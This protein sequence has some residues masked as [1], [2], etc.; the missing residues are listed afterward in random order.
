MYCRDVLW[1]ALQSNCSTALQKNSCKT[2]VVVNFYLA[3]RPRPNPTS[4]LSQS[5]TPTSWGARGPPRV[6]VAFLQK[7]VRVILHLEP[8]VMSSCV[9]CHVS[10]A[11]RLFYTLYTRDESLVLAKSYPLLQWVADPTS[12]SSGVAR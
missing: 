1:V 6:S 9:N 12:A 2:T 7:T 10:C 3:S 4:T 5:P 11:P 8:L